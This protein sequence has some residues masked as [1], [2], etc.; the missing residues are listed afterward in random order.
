MNF[1]NLNQSAHSDR[2]FAFIGNRMRLKRKVVVGHWQ[3]E[4]VQSDVAILRT[5]FLSFSNILAPIQWKDNGIQVHILEPLAS[6]SIDH[7][8]SKP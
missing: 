1:M 8:L 2:E 4:D 6:S 3:D 5:A 7:P